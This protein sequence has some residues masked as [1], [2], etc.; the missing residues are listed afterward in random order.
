MYAPEIKFYAGEMD[1]DGNFQ[2]SIADL[3]VAGDSA[4]LSR[5]IVAAAATG[6][7]AEKGIA[8]GL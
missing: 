1:V 3:Y 2:T 8:F 4:G 6:V 5:G 7:L